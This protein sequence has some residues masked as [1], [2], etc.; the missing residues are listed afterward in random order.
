[1]D[2][3]RTKEQL[4]CNQPY[5]HS[6]RKQKIRTHFVCVMPCIFGNMKLLQYVHLSIVVSLCS[7]TNDSIDCQKFL[8]CDV[9]TLHN[10]YIALFFN[11][12]EFGV[13][14]KANFI[15]YNNGCGSMS[16]AVK[17]MRGILAMLNSSLS[18][19]L[20]KL[21]LFDQLAVLRMISRLSL[22]KV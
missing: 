19:L 2:K 4:H 20:I 10:T 7:H 13:V 12:G 3:A 5:I 17:T 15:G 6:V 16:V 11:L 18:S 22:K 21:W 14:Y 1:M 8:T 9:Y